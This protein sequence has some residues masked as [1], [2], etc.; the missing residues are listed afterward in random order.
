MDENRLLVQSL[1]E[2]QALSERLFRIQ[3]KISTRA[4]LDEV[5]GTIT[6]GAAELLGDEVV[7]LRLVSEEDPDAM[8]MVASVGIPD[9]VAPELLILRVGEGL[10]GMAV[11]EDRL[12]IREGYDE[13]EGA[14]TPFVAGGRPLP[15][16]RNGPRAESSYDHHREHP[17]RPRRGLREGGTPGP[18]PD[19]PA[20][21]APGLHPASAHSQIS[22]FDRCRRGGSRDQGRRP[23]PL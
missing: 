18:A 20:Q 14:L 6:S 5:L 4:P 11:A 3:R 2:R 9:D 10:G 8:E 12:C 21:V 16:A 7:G 17:S 13:W 19:R 15:P 1:R 22:P 23:Q